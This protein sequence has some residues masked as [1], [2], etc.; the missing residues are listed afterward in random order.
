MLDIDDLEQM[1]D[2]LIGVLA[3]MVNDVKMGHSDWALALM[4][5]ARVMLTGIESMIGEFRER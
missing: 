5:E 3:G 2:S 4:D 1:V